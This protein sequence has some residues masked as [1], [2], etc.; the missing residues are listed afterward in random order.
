VQ[1]RRGILCSLLTAALGAGLASLAFSASPHAFVAAPVAPTLSWT[2]PQSLHADLKG[3]V[4]LLR[5]DTLDVY[6]LG[7]RQI[8]RPRRLQRAGLVEDG[9]TCAALAP[10]GSRWIATA[11]NHVLSFRNGQAEAVPEPGWLVTSVGFLGDMALAGV[12]PMS[13]GGFPASGHPVTPP[14]ILK[15]QGAGWST[16]VGGRLPSRSREHDSMDALFAE[17]TIRLVGDGAHHLWVSYPY[18]GQIVRYTPA[19]RQDLQ[20][21]VGNGAARFHEDEGRLLTFRERLRSQGYDTANAKMGVFSA[22]LGI[23]G[24]AV[25]PDGVLYLV[26]DRSLT[27][28]DTLLARFDSS[29]GLVES[30]PLPLAGEGE[31]SLASGRDGLYL[32][33]ARGNDGRW[34][35]AWDAIDH[36]EWRELSNVRLVNR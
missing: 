31:L 16:Y 22:K 35:I 23:R 29:R 2:A 6:P 11:A 24:M 30:T 14:L 28:R 32:A 26:L 12:L 34:R 15:L 3:N 1:V 8:Q 9:M 17:H 5:G 25:A 18:L 36:A 33:G 7:S 19:G 10:D 20:L 21:V 13:V 4:F 27:G